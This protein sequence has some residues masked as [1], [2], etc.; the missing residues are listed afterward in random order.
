MY[1]VGAHPTLSAPVTVDVAAVLDAYDP[2]NLTETT[3][4]MLYD[5]ATLQRREWPIDGQGPPAP[6][7]WSSPSAP[8]TTVTRR[9]PHTPHLGPVTLGPLEIKTFVW[10]AN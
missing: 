8:A 6:A 7:S 2:L 1:E 9:P 3:L 5:W 4:T 10:M